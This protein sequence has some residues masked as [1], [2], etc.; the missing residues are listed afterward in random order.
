[1]QFVTGLAVRELSDTS[2]R[3]GGADTSK[4]HETSL[5][6]TLLQMA[7]EIETLH[8]NQFMQSEL[9][10]DLQRT[11]RRVKRRSQAGGARSRVRSPRMDR[12]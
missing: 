3:S 8:R 4:A 1:M 11:L 2:N 7:A 12:H 10:A 6:L 5:H 9:I